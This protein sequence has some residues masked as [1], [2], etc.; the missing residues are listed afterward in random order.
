VSNRWLPDSQA[1]TSSEIF[2][3][4]I[5]R[6]RSFSNVEDGRIDFELVLEPVERQDNAFRHYGGS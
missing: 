6:G 3:L 1:D 2:D 4:L 5:A